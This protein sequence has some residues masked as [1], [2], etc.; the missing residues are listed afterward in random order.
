MKT[1]VFNVQHENWEDDGGEH[2]VQIKQ[3]DDALFAEL[4]NAKGSL[5][6]DESPMTELEKAPDLS[7]TT[8]PLQVDA[9]FTFWYSYDED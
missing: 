9:V 7:V 1:I 5:V 3:V 6:M 2:D 4:E 8:W